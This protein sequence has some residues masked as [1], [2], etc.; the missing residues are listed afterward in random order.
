MSEIIEFNFNNKTIACVVGGGN[1]W[2]KAREVATVLGYA[3]TKQAIIK[4]IDSDD[5]QTYE[6]LLETLQVGGSL[7]ETLGSNNKYAIFINKPGLYSPILRS[8]KQEAKAFKQW[9]CAEVLLSSRKHGRYET[10]A[11]AIH[12]I[13]NPTGETKLH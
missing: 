11:A 3:T 7:G 2:F 12:R 13:Q 9:V 6:Q 8:G 5:K 4:N 10:P 1:P